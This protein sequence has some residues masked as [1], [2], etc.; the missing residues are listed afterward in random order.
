MQFI[1]PWYLGP[2]VFVAHSIM[3]EHGKNGKEIVKRSEE[4]SIYIVRSNKMTSNF[5]M[6]IAHI[7]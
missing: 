7:G 1:G 6:D 2:L 3:R 5:F 4:V